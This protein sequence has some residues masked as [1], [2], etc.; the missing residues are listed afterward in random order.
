MGWIIVT[1][2]S[3][4]ILSALAVGSFFLWV[5]VSDMGGVVQVL[6]EKALGPLSAPVPDELITLDYPTA[7]QQSLLLSGLVKGACKCR[8]QL[9]LDP[10]EEQSMIGSVLDML[11][12]VRYKR[13][14]FQ[15]VIPNILCD[16]C[17]SGDYCYFNPQLFLLG[18]GVGERFPKP[19]VKQFLVYLDY[20]E[21]C[22]AK[23]S[24]KTIED[25]Q[26]TIIID[27]GGN[28]VSP[29][30]IGEGSTTIIWLVSLKRDKARRPS[31]IEIPRW[32]EQSH[33]VIG[34]PTL[35]DEA[36][37]NF[38]MMIGLLVSRGGLRCRIIDSKKVGQYKPERFWD[39]SPRCTL[40]LPEK[41]DRYQQVHNATFINISEVPES[42]ISLAIL[43]LFS[44]N[45]LD[46]LGEAMMATLIPTL[47]AIDPKDHE[48]IGEG[49]VDH[50]EIRDHTHFMIRGKGA[51]SKALTTGQ[52]LLEIKAVLA[53]IHPDNEL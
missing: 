41:L 44:L 52:L 13:N 30:S 35:N 22:F 10:I 23:F 15:Q 9:F 37:I 2:V 1:V 8:L 16:R 42:T 33:M 46:G 12:P 11:A 24:S 7:I 45:H 5:Y 26:A 19:L 32:H 17:F 50:L 21:S 40:I 6:N 27:Y 48:H 47:V 20:L 25:G 36:L 51:V 39:M 38:A 49:A 4:V 14:Y 28:G 18:E 3:G 29:E 34:A 31:G 43:L 53:K